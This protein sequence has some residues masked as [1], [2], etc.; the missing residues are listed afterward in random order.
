MRLQAREFPVDPDAPFDNDAVGLRDSAEALTNLLRNSSGPGVIAVDGEWG[1][2]KTTFLSMW[3]AAYRKEGGAVVEYNAWR[4]DYCEDVLVSLIHEMGE[5][6]ADQDQP[7]DKTRLSE[8]KKGTKKLLTDLLPLG[9]RL[10]TSGLINIENIDT[11]VLT[12]GLGDLADRKM[13]AYADSRNSL[14]NFKESLKAFVDA[15]G[16][17]GAGELPVVVVV[18]ELDRC[19]PDYSLKV[20]EHIKHLFDVDGL[21]FVLGV[22]LEQ[23]ANAIAGVYG[24]N[25]DARKYLSRFYDLRLALPPCENMAALIEN[26]LVRL[27]S[28]RLFPKNEKNYLGNREQ[29]LRTLEQLVTIFGLSKRSLLRILVS[30]AGYVGSLPVNARVFPFFT[31]YFAVVRYENRSAYANIA[32]GKLGPDEVWSVISQNMP[33]DFIQSHL[34][35]ILHVETLLVAGGMDAV[36][37]FCQE[38]SMKIND[39][40]STDHEKELVRVAFHV[41]D[42]AQSM[43]SV[44]LA[45]IV[46]R[47]ELLGAQA[48][49]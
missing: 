42:V 25:Y 27:G 7:A 8:L 40:K 3:Q 33:D 4:N 32:S 12:D 30:L 45:S 5:Q 19:R 17:S 24:P 11:D 9:V 15:H 23:L 44:P 1:S 38:L 39:Q 41:R 16:A 22:D 35:R 28:E 31:A 36:H 13:Q 46:R 47:M 26:F 6:L 43:T 20:L 34:G 18:D 2:G 37:R 21:V 48:G 14:T 10:A 29:L 49:Q